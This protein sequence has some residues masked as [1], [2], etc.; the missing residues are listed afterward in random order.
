MEK[1]YYEGFFFFFLVIKKKSL[2][3]EG[4]NRYARRSTN[5]QTRIN[6]KVVWVGVITYEIRLSHFTLHDIFI[7]VLVWVARATA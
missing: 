5:V 1:V 3:G 7:T 6:T 4:G 2:V